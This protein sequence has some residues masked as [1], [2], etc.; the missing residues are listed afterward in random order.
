MTYIRT[1]IQYHATTLLLY[2]PSLVIAVISITLHLIPLFTLC[3]SASLNLN[4]PS[5]P[6]CD[7]PPLSNTNTPARRCAN[8]RPARL[9]RVVYFAGLSKQTLG[10]C[11][12]SWSSFV[13]F[14]LPHSTLRPLSAAG[15]A[16]NNAL[17]SLQ[18]VHAFSITLVVLLFYTVSNMTPYWRGATR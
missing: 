6:A 13:S 1:Y 8:A 12:V 10:R 9:T 18:E 16:S 2:A 3:L 4:N 15:Q 7:N 5:R 11:P 17:H 14:C